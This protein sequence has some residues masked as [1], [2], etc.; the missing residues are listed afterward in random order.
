MAHRLA[1]PFVL[2]FVIALLVQP[3][4]LFAQQPARPGAAP[5]AAP[6][7]RDGMP[8]ED[9]RIGPEDVLA[10]SVWK[11]DAMSKVV[12]VR[13]DGM[14]SMPLVDDVKAAGL[15]P[16]QLRDIIAQKL[17]EY[18]PSPTVSVVVNDVRSFKVAVIGEVLRPARYDLKARTTLLE[19]LAL[20]GGFNQFASRTRLVVLRTE[21]TKQTRLPVN[22][23]RVIGGEDENFAL[24]PGDIVIVP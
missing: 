6:V 7:P 21:G 9:Y 23:N 16:M 22:Y 8:L 1:L 19:V 4:S 15:T 14:I 2:S 12:P 3:L 13:P 24:K 18:V 10:I 5:A 11:N 17:N 20:A